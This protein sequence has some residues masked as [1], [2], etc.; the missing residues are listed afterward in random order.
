MLTVQSG[1]FHN[2][3]LVHVYH[4]LWPYLPVWLSCL[5]HLLVTD[6]PSYTFLS[7]ACTFLFMY[8]SRYKI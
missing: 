4:G 3:I 5:T 1:G 6:S 2:D 7:C 8:M